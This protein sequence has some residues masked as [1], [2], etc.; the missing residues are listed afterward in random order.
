MLIVPSRYEPGSIV[1]G[2]ALASGLPVVL[3]DEVGPSEV[4]SGP[5]VRV[6]RAGDVDG[7]EAAVRSL[8]AAADGERQALADAARTDAAR[9]FSVDALMEQLIGML[10]EAGHNLEASRRAIDDSIAPSRHT[11]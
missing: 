2:E 9:L 5:H 6:H 4:V 8:L 3:S 11:T 10:R 1:T 7:L